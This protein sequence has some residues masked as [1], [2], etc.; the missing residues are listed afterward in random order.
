MDNFVAMNDID[1]PEDLIEDV[2][3]LI[4]SKD[5]RIDYA[6]IQYL[7]MSTTLTLT[8]SVTISLSFPA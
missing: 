4:D 6:S 1:A 3:G 5:P 7:R 2:E 8:R